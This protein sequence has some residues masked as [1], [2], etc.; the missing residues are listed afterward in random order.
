M[1]R[2]DILWRLLKS[3]LPMLFL[4][5]MA[6]SWKHLRCPLVVEWT[7]EHLHDGVM[8]FSWRTSTHWSIIIQHWKEILWSHEKTCREL[9]CM[10]LWK[11]WIWKTTYCMIPAIC[12]L[13]K[14]KI[15]DTVKRSEVTR[16][17]GEEWIGRVK[18]NF[19]VVKWLCIQTVVDTLFIHLSKPIKFQQEWTLVNTMDFKW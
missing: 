17:W 6:K 5:I 18:K 4:F 10:L 14:G 9:R 13:G 1:I 11:K 7:V 8:L 16:G 3:K 12:H 2:A 19:R 15:M